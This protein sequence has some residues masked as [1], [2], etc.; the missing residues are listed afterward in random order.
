[1]Y[2]ILAILLIL[3]QK[4]MTRLKL[5]SIMAECQ[6]VKKMKLWKRLKLVK[7]ISF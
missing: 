2:H 1:M 6:R 3:W 4:W 7:R 5:V